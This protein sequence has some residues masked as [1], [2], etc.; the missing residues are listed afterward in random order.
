MG[1]FYN[2]FNKKESSNEK[3]DDVNLEVINFEDEDEIISVI[4]A[5]LT[6]IL[7]KGSNNF[8]VKNIKRTPELDSIWSLTGRMKLMR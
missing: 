1:L 5:A 2:I 3:K 7:E 6:C 4:T 8:F